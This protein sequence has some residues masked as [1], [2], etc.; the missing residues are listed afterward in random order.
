VLLTNTDICAHSNNIDT[1]YDPETRPR[2][3]AAGGEGDA[4]CFS[5]L[6]KKLSTSVAGIKRAKQLFHLALV[7]TVAFHQ[8]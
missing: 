1:N 7:P 4:L 6:G 5:P 2:E 3:A 8:I